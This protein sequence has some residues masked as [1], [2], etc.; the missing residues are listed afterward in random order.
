M[1]TKNELISATNGSDPSS[2]FLE[3]EDVISGVSIDDRTIQKG[4]LYIAIKGDNFDGHDFIES[5]ILKGASGVIVS[6]EQYAIKWKALL[7]RHK[8]FT[9]K[10]C[11]ILKK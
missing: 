3:N 8:S 10:Y 1:W 9:Q 4:D 11:T 2:N 6:E 7:K 5:A